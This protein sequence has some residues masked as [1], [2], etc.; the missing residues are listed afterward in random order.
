MSVFTKI[1]DT[2]KGVV[3]KIGK[4]SII[5]IGRTVLFA[6]P[7]IIEDVSNFVGMAPAEKVDALCE[8]IRARTGIEAGAVD[9]IK[10]LPAD[11]EDRFFNALA[12]LVEII[13][14]NR[15][16]V[17]G[18]FVPGTPIAD[19]TA[20]VAYLQAVL[21]PADSPLA[22]NSSEDKSVLGSELLALNIL[23][24]QIAMVQAIAKG[25]VTAMR[26][27]QIR[28]IAG[29]VVTVA[30]LLNRMAEDLYTPSN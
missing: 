17:Q 14:K 27:D 25:Q 2:I 15:L 1:W 8:E 13:A 7:A 21:L 18:Y 19:F 5:D 10:D 23:P 22:V 12:V 11:Q 6:I 20:S 28:V 16:S 30:N 26:D 9:I 29:L 3:P 4:V 24:A